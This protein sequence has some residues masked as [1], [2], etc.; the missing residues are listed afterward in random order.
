MALG[1][2]WWRAWF[3]YVA[4]ALCA[5]GVV[6]GSIDSHFAWQAWHWNA[7]TSILCGRRGTWR[8]RSSLCL[9]GVALMAR[10]QPFHFTHHSVT[11]TSTLH[12]RL[13]PIFHTQSIF[14]M[15]HHAT[16]S[17][18]ALSHAHTH[19]APSHTTLSHTTLSHTCHM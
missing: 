19:T 13:S 15:Q 12:I 7:S 16:L 6:I 18:T 11:D 17:H 5:A 10:T 14:H 2:L 1:C 8:H 9:A 3:P 4:T